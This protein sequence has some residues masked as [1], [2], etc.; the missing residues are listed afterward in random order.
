VHD[1][2]EDSNEKEHKVGKKRR[3]SKRAKS[4]SSPREFVI[5]MNHPFEAHSMKEIHGIA[6]EWLSDAPTFKSVRDHVISLMDQF[7]QENNEKVILVGHS[8]VSD[9]LAL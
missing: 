2:T 5:E 9:I 1:S 7:Y 8:V 4:S 3:H 6:Q